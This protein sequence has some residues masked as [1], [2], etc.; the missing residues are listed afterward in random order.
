MAVAPMSTTLNRICYCHAR[1]PLHCLGCGAI[2]IPSSLGAGGA[3]LSASLDFW[4]RGYPRPN[5]NCAGCGAIRV[6]ITLLR[7]SARLPASQAPLRTA[8][9]G[10]PAYHMRLEDVWLPSRV[11]THDATPFGIFCLLSVGFNSSYIHVFTLVAFC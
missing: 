10:L 5:L 9:A 2:R 8:V 7:S 6:P 1:L 11:G 3:E 4:V